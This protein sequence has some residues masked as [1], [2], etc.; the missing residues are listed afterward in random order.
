[1]PD[2]ALLQTAAKGELKTSQQVAQQAKRMLDA[3]YTRA[4][5]VDF[6]R[7]WL[8]FNRIHNVGKA[9]AVFPSWNAAIPELMETE[10]ERFVEQ[11]VF[12]GEGTWDALLSAPY[13]MMNRTLADFYQL[14]HPN[15]DG[16]TFAK[17]AF[18]PLQRAG[19][20]SQGALLAVNAHTNQTS[21]VHR[22]KLIRE[23]F[24]CEV[25][26]AP[27]PEVM[28]T[29]PEPKPGSTARERFALHSDNAS[30]RGCHRMMDPL[31]FGFERLDGVGIHRQTESGNAIDDSGEV[32]GTDVPGS[33][34]GVRGLA[35]K[36]RDSKQA[37]R[38]YVK[39]WFRFAYGRGELPEDACSLERIDTAFERDGRDIKKLILSLTQTD[40][41]LYRQSRQTP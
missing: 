5:V 21:P 35:N 12:D 18:D 34:Q 17:T 40:A 11:V 22:G 2:E 28:I 26:G 31:G 25:L 33:F 13:S 4:Q 30:C 7:Q 29:V 41:F 15:E 14:P 24:F 23:S 19:L 8:D 1:M 36:L 3:S 6:H 37:R 27:P 39:Q 9:A 10:S 16:G 38:C 32:F 20:L